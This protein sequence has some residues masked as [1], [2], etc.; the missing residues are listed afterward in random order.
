[1]CGFVF[2]RIHIILHQMCMCKVCNIYISF[3]LQYIAMEDEL[4]ELHQLLRIAKVPANL[5]LKLAGSIDQNGLFSVFKYSFDVHCL[6]DI[7]PNEYEE[8]KKTLIV[9]LIKANQ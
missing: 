3:A 9:S 4:S 2:L 8:V 5:P 6:E 1:M 7:N